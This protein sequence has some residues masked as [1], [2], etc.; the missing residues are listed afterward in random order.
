MKSSLPWSWRPLGA[1]LLSYAFDW[2]AAASSSSSFPHQLCA[3]APPPLP[4][5]PKPGTIASSSSS[6][7]AVSVISGGFSPPPEKTD[8]ASP[9]RSRHQK[10]VVW[11]L[12]A[13]TKRC[14]SGWNASDQTF[15]S[16]ACE[17]VARGPGC[18]IADKVL[19]SVDDERSQCKI[20]PYEP[21]D[22][23]SG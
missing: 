2:P 19:G 12:D 3:T 22:T 10:R 7:P 6:C 1:N 21:P 18:C 9:G 17:S 14:P 23:R 4:P 16:C 20:A 15:E 8:V 13:L 5:K 11:S